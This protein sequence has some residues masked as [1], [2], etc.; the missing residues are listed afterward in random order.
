M[1]V[2]S[3]AAS[4]IPQE[5]TLPRVVIVD[6]D[7]RVQQSVADLLAVSGE[8][9]VV[10]RAGDVRAALEEVER[11]RPDVVLIDP[12]LPDA[13]AGLALIGGLARARPDLRLVLTGWSDAEAL[14]NGTTC[15]VRKGGSPE[16]FVDAIVAGCRD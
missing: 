16:E 13:E 1:E 8:V 14:L 15:Y 5:A 9:E 11:T 10:G 3:G 7:R 4:Q 6:A 12:R 2:V